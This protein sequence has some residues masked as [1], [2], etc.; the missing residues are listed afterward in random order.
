MTEPGLTAAVTLQMGVWFRRIDSPLPTL[1]V[2][3]TSS[4]RLSSG[5][6]S[7]F[8]LLMV[9]LIVRVKF[10]SED[11]KTRSN[12]GGYIGSGSEVSS[13]SR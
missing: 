13:N 9:D 2:R 4:V 3:P 11:A 5:A 8:A 10:K 7:L 6:I 1:F 12:K